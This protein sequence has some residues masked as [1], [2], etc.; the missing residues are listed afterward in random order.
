M[1]L[2]TYGSLCTEVY[3]ITK[4]IAGEY[5]DV[6]YFIEH[7]SSIDGKILEAMVGKGCLLIPLLEAGLN[8]EGID[9]SSDMLAA[10][11]RNCAAR[12]LNP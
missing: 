4:P 3:E 2:T 5:P 10:C 9:A 1:K 7:L 12:G 6:P 8:V 11:R